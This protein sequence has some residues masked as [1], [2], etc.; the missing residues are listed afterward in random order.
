M[1]LCERRRTWR[2]RRIGA[3]RAKGPEQGDVGSFGCFRRPASPV[4]ATRRTVECIFGGREDGAAVEEE[5]ALRRSKL[6][7]RNRAEIP[8][9]L[10]INPGK[11]IFFACLFVCVRRLALPACV[12]TLSSLSLESL[13]FVSSSIPQVPERTFC[14]SRSKILPGAGRFDFGLSLFSSSSVKSKEK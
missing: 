13:F 9:R 2:M 3:W 14:S 8:N 11:N 7:G 6:S 10:L 12:P 4:D 1:S 5:G